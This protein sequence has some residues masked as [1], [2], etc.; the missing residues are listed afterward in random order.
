[1]T[2]PMRDGPRLA[3][4]GRHL[5]KIP[6]TERVLVAHPTAGSDIRALLDAMP[7]P[8]AEAAYRHQLCAEAARD[9]YQQGRVSGYIQAVEDFKAMQHNAVRDLGRYL[10]RWHVCCGSCRRTGHRPGCTR[11]EGRTRETYG[12]SHPD[13]YPGEEAAS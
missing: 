1:M 11:C 5:A 9:G 12:R 4:T 2:T 8:A 10:D 7:D 13:D 3:S 6:A